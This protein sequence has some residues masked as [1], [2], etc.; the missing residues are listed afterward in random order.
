MLRLVRA[1]TPDVATRRAID[2]ESAEVMVGVKN[3]LLV[4]GCMG[5]ELRIIEGQALRRAEHGGWGDF[6]HEFAL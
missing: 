6:R 5:N 3:I 4:H 1:V 2:L